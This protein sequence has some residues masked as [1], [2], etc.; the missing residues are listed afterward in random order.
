MERKRY[1]WWQANVF[2]HCRLLR[3][4]WVIV[5]QRLRWSTCSDPLCVGSRDRMAESWP[6]QWVEGKR[7]LVR[8]SQPARYGQAG[9]VRAGRVQAWPM[10]GAF[11]VRVRLLA[12]AVRFGIA[13]YTQRSNSDAAESFRT[14]AGFLRR[15][16]ADF[17]HHSATF[18][19]HSTTP[20]VRIVYMRYG[21][22]AGSHLSHG[23][24]NLNFA[25]SFWNPFET[26]PNSTSS[27]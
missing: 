16:R 10:P 20:P 15:R 7:L 8:V 12:A 4:L 14:A 25:R 24:Q 26:R 11:Q 1:H 13:C 27:C 22:A 18:W 9:A 2:T 5:G 6:S 19:H 3:I 23:A 21:W 17:W